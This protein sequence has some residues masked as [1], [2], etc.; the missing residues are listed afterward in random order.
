M[1]IRVYMSYVYCGLFLLHVVD[2]AKARTLEE[3]TCIG[4]GVRSLKLS[5]LVLARSKKSGRF[6]Q[7]AISLS[8]R[9][10]GLD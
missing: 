9:S 6:A 3:P 1:Y 5:G 4:K 8:L 2:S 10:E 7:V